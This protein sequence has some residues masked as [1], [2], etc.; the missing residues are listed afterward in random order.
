MIQQNILLPTLIVNI[1]KSLQTGCLSVSTQDN[2]YFLWFSNGYFLGCYEKNF[3][4]A[5]YLKK[6]NILE[7]S[8][9]I[10]FNSLISKDSKSV[11]QVVENL[12]S[13]NS[14]KI[15]ND[16]FDYQIRLI[17]KLV[18]CKLVS[19]E[20]LQCKV[21]DIPTINL[22]GLKQN[23]L[24]LFLYIMRKVPIKVLFHLYENDIP[25]SNLSI[26]NT[27]RK[28]EFEYFND[29]E[30]RFWELSDSVL[31]CRDL[32]QNGDMRQL[33]Q[34]HFPDLK[35][36]MACKLIY[37]SLFILGLVS[38]RPSPSLQAKVMQQIGYIK[39]TEFNLDMGKRRNK[40]VYGFAFTFLFLVIIDAFGLF[41][42]LFEKQLFDVLVKARGF[43]N[44]NRVTVVSIDESDI[45]AMG[46][47]RNFDDAYLAQ[48]LENLVAADPVVIGIDLYRNLPVD[49]GHNRLNQIFQDERILGVYK[50][51]EPDPVDPPPGLA[52]TDRIGFSDLALDPDGIVRRSILAAFV[53]GR[54]FDSLGMAASLKYLKSQYSIEEGVTG[55][56]TTLGSLRLNPLGGHSGFYR[57]INA[58]G[59]QQMIDWNLGLENVDRI[60]LADIYSNQFDPNLVKGRII[61]IGTTT[62]SVAD[63]FPTPFSKQR[64]GLQPSY[65]VVVHA[66]I[67]EG[68]VAAALGET[69]FLAPLPYLAI[70][71]TYGAIFLISA[72]VGVVVLTYENLDEQLVPNWVVVVG[73]GLV[74][75]LSLSTA[76]WILF[77][78][79]IIL[80]F[81][82]V[83]FGLTSYG[84][85]VNFFSQ[86]SKELYF[87][88]RLL[89][90]GN[91]RYLNRVLEER[92]SRQL[93][94]VVIVCKFDAEQIQKDLGILSFANKAIGKQI[95]QSKSLIRYDFST[96]VIVL[97]YM[98]VE[99][100]EELANQLQSTLVGC[101]Y[102]NLENKL[103]LQVSPISNTFSFSAADL[104]SKIDTI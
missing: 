21:T 1:G 40:G 46:N 20:F 93:A 5:E 15:L 59:F 36:Y 25:T 47:W 88:D 79:G 54:R 82:L 52:G 11:K 31:T 91:K 56:S 81:A 68:L 24:P 77:N 96:L 42:S 66:N 71:I 62:D 84:Y 103:N 22:S 32:S 58:G 55:G 100:L 28:F 39:A 70:L 89:K 14:T 2:T 30:I 104:Y 37:L 44:N 87:S 8:K 51:G 48:T 41:S 92:I 53:D 10:A 27:I 3:K 74:L 19:S 26:S 72:G 16:L 64:G 73:G 43:R 101:D 9:S 83:L 38:S 80:N 75:G 49:P 50:L 60:S 45:E 6:N 29:A 12:F 97:D 95:V 94:Y 65:G 18:S 76:I 78:K 33:L 57:G 98:K 7:G 86:Y 67:A 35:P 61:F 34:S 99:D 90:I 69:Q 85:M 4:I 102:S 13:Q 63:Y 17:L 23:Y